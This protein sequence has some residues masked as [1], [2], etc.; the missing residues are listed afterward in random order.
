[1]QLQE[2]T[3]DSLEKER[4]PSTDELCS[5]IPILSEYCRKLDDH[6]KRRYLEKIA[7]VGVD[8]VTIPDEQ[9]NS[10]CLPLI[11]ATDLLSYLVLETSFYTKQ[12]FKTYKSL[13]AYNFMVSGFIT[14]IPGCIVSGKH[15]VAGKVRHSQRMNDSLISVW[16][17]AEKD[18][19]VTSAHC[20]GCKVG[21]AE[22]CS[23]VASVL[24]YIEA[25][26]RIRG[27][28]SCTE[29]KCTWLLPS[30]VKEVPYAKM[31]YINLTSAR[32]LKADLDEKIENLGENREATS[33]TS[34]SRKVTVQFPTQTEMDNFYANLNKSRIKPVAL[35]LIEPYSSQFVSQSRS[36]PTIP[37]LFDDEN[38]KLSYTD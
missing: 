20:L 37:D 31:Q 26:T 25:W 13:E 11:E 32:K 7:E 2:I 30:F 18:G 16:V 12:Q 36:I 14:S 3:M 5:K 17:I 10:E 22:S 38:L 6:V 4:V 28:L 33:S 34:S 23:H 29:V 1:M 15:V 9:F 19:T 27:K 35:S 8:P 21:L 24:F